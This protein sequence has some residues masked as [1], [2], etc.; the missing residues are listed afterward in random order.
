M[1]KKDTWI[2]LIDAVAVALEKAEAA[3]QEQNS[4]D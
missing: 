2:P 3:W 1:A 4:N